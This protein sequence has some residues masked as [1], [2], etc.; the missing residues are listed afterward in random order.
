M[1]NIKYVKMM[2]FRKFKDTTIIFNEHLN[3]IIGENEAG[4]STVVEAIDIAIN[5]LYKNADKSIIKELINIEDYND[6]KK[7]PSIE[8]LPKIYIDVGL[9]LDTSINSSTYSGIEYYNTDKKT[10]NTGIAF[11]CEFNDELKDIASTIISNGNIPYE[12]YSFKWKTF[13]GAPYN[14]LIKPIKYLGINTSNIET[15]N[16][17]NNY[18]KS[19]FN[20]KVQELDRV[21]AKGNYSEKIDKIL[22]DEIFTIDENR[23]FGINRKKV[24]L[25]NIINIVEGGVPIENKG[26]G[27]ENLIKTKMALEKKSNNDIISIE[28]PENHLS[29]N[30]LRKMIKEIEDREKSAQIIIT[31]HSSMIVSSLNLKNVILLNNSIPKR[32]NELDD[33][34]ADY[35]NKSDNN[36]L[37]EFI[38]SKRVILVEGNTEYILFPKFY[39]KINKSSIDKDNISIISVGGLGYKNFVYIAEILDKEMVVITDN[40]KN[41]EKIKKINDYNQKS[42]KIK[43]YTDQDKNRWTIEVCIYED[44]KELLDKVIQVKDNAKYYFNGNDYGKT[45]GKMLNNKTDTAIKILSEDIEIPSYIKG[46]MEWIKKLC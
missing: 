21:K 1:N 41:E 11:K 27:M 3:I 25:E 10:N 22:E 26:S 12:C 20:N 9:E 45:L 28:E 19:L 40:D 24:I 31:T 36:K 5:Q 46:A 23:K 37:L 33:T 18:N 4:K 39:E 14:S 8:N 6:F 42:T 7:H 44:N 17:Y 34:V 30:N 32:F 35:F 29:Y 16:T 13:A 43:I 38:L 2:G 15:N